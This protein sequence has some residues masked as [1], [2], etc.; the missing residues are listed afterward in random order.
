M[1][2]NDQQQYYDFFFFFNL[3]LDS[4]F[5]SNPLSMVLTISFAR[6]S[7]AFEILL[8]SFDDV[9]TKGI[10]YFSPSYF[11][12]FFVTFLSFSKSDFDP[13]NIIFAVEEP[14]SLI[15]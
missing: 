14:L 13:T 2:K 3:A 1:S 11:P 7:N 15:C 10:L 5:T 4:Y 9:Y 12:C 6:I 8:L